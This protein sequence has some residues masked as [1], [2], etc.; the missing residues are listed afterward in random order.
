MHH[1]EAQKSDLT[2]NA[3]T[4]LTDRDVAR[5][6]K[7]AR[8]TLQKDRLRGGGIPFIRLGRLVRYR[9]SDVSAFV[10]AQ[11]ALHSTSGNGQPFG[12]PSK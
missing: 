7:R 11:P 12:R 10:A 8:A 5:L 1:S 9:Q 6:T 2:L 4:L 3:E